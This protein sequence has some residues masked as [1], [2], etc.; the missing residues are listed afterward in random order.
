MMNVIKTSAELAD[1][2]EKS[3]SEPVV[4]FKHSATCPFSARA[5]EQVSDAKHDLTIGAIVVQYAP[6]LKE[7]IAE[8]LG[9][10]HQSPQAITVFEGKAVSSYWREEIQKETLMQEATALQKN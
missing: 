3:H 7:E 1:L 4:I 10:E 8:K 5:Q 2:L 9:V 6:D